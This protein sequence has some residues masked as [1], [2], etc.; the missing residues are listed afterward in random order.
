SA[1][2]PHSISVM[3]GRQRTSLE[4]QSSQGIYND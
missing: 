1:G 3:G 2:M 4:V